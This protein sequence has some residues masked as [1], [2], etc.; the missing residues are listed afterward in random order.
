MTPIYDESLIQHPYGI[1]SPHSWEKLVCTNIYSNKN[2]ILEKNWHACRKVNPVLCFKFC[3]F[4]TN[5]F[6]QDTNEVVK[7][8]YRRQI[9][10]R[11]K[12]VECLPQAGSTLLFWKMF[13]KYDR[14]FENGHRKDRYNWNKVPEIKVLSLEESLKIPEKNFNLTIV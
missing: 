9:R 5:I 2:I 13:V 12:K 11:L 7:R 10:T 1:K 3:W 14:N 6:S 4:S 8:W